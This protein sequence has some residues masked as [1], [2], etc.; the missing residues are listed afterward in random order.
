MGRIVI[1]KLA[2]SCYDDMMISPKSGIKI[3]NGFLIVTQE[4]VR[5]NTC[6]SFCVVY[7]RFANQGLSR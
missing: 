4:E 1:I 7:H 3:E 6:R 5:F 2:S